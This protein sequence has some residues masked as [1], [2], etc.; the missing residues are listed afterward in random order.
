LNGANG[1]KIEV[2]GHGN[3]FVAYGNHPSGEQLSWYG[4]FPGFELGVDDLTPI[5]ED[6]ITAFLADAARLIGAP[7]IPAAAPI[8]TQHAG[9][10]ARLDDIKAAL[11][12]TTALADS[13]HTWIKI[14]LA[15]HAETG[16]SDDGFALWD[17]WSRTSTKYN[18]KAA[19]EAWRSFSP[20]DIAIGSLFHAAKEAVPGWRAPSWDDDVDEDNDATE[21][22]VEEIRTP[23]LAI[24]SNRK[25][26]APPLPL[27]AF[28][29]FW[30]AWISDASQASS[31]PPDYTA[32]PLLTV[33]AG[34]IGN[35]RK[36]QVWYNWQEPCVLWAATVGEPSAGKTPGAAPVMS[37]MLPLVEV[38]MARDYPAQRDEW[39]AKEIVSSALNDAWKKEVAQAAC[40]GDQIP[41]MPDGINIPPKPVEP[42]AR[43]GNV[44]MEKLVS[45]V[46]SLPKGVLSCHDELAGWLLNLNRY[47]G[48][49]TDRPFWLESYMGGS[50]RVDRQ[51]LDEPIRIPHLSVSIFGTIQPE[52][53]AE[54]LKGADDGLASRFLWSWP[55]SQPF[56]R[57][58]RGADIE[59][60]A[61][62]L[63]RLA[64]L[65][66][67]ENENGALNP[68]VLPLTADASDALYKY[69]GT[70]GRREK[71]AF[72]LLKGTV[73]KA[74]GHTVRI[75]LALEFLWWCAG[76]I[77]EPTSI[78]KHA[79]EQAVLLMEEYFLPMAERVFGDAAI[80]IEERN[81]R[82]LAAWIRRTRPE[83]INVSK[84]RDEA[85]LDGL[86]ESSDVKNAFRFLV[87]A[88]WLS[89]PTKTGRPGRP[90]G[91][92]TVNPRLWEMLAD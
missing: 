30:S 75:A 90:A 39:T 25:F 34:L 4:G 91:T 58:E 59:A 73:G 44:T 40:N 5:T 57:P 26:R 50:Y 29:P 70:L 56:Q 33:A 2:L 14:G 82:T 63:K 77:P 53:L 15:I 36:V 19:K 43:I 60:G 1:D 71:T 64:D 27:S 74:R 20:R 22:A 21:D 67:S 16:G 32:I 62:A 52:K 51:K 76:A 9:K 41:P 72:G 66:L 28:G 79:V 45:I 7:P 46:S 84:V 38:H 17:E 81:A 85:R 3:Q 65:T 80:P 10:A 31:A 89:P 18:S 23:S 12:V 78:S 54:A 86:R 69:I 49:G 48:A 47:S 6:E 37:G 11:D 87:E 92:Y 42:C 13:S 61:S 55:E 8:T 24:L 68:V 35:S 88:G 83:T